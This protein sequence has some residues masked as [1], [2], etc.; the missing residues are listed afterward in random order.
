MK[1]QTVS[2]VNGVLTVEYPSIGKTFRADLSKYPQS[3]REDALEHGFKQKFGDAASGKTPAEKYAMVQRIH[4]SLLAGEWELTATPDRS[5]IIKEAVSRIKK[6]K[7]AQ[8]DKLLDALTEEQRTA[9]L[10][11]WSTHA[12]VKAEIAKIIAER[13]AKAAD[14]QDEDLDIDL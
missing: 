10:K 2:V 11:E 13:A 6:V 8:L 9:K 7:I 5:P 14:E 4:D 12:K 3:I 1:K